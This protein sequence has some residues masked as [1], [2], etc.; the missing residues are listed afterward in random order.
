MNSPFQQ[1]KVIKREDGEI[2]R[3]EDINTD[4]T[5]LDKKAQTQNGC[6]F[7]YSNERFTDCNTFDCCV[8]L[9]MTAQ[10]IGSLLLVA[11]ETGSTTQ[12][13]E[14]SGVD[15]VIEETEAAVSLGTISELKK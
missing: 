3:K 6:T 12:G 8:F 13:T 5:N 11:V 9:S 14:T 1:S 2:K 7:R 15:E 4:K 10:D